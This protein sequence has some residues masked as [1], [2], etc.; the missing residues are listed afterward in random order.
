MSIWDTTKT[1]ETIGLVDNMVSIGSTL[2][3]RRVIDKAEKDFREGYA[4]A[5][6]EAK[7]TGIMPDEF[8]RTVPVDQMGR[9]VGVKVVALRELGKISPGHP[10]VV[11]ST[12]R[13]NIATQTLINYNRADRPDD[14]DL[15]NFAPSDVAAQKIYEFS[16]SR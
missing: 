16:I 11:S 4:R 2:R 14:A 12:V 15:T 5:L 8:Q 1:I 13:Q 10:L 7:R 6:S 9:Q 3:D